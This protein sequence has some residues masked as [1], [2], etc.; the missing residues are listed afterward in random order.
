M[1][2]PW[3]HVTMSRVL[4][5][6]VCLT[7]VSVCFWFVLSHLVVFEDLNRVQHPCLGLLLEFQIQ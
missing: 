4:P 1:D 7:Q 6:T 2:T 3:G 5:S